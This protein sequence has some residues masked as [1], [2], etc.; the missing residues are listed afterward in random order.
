MHIVEIRF[1]DGQELPFPSRN[2]AFARADQAREF[3]RRIGI[4][5]KHTG[6]V[7]IIGPERIDTTTAARAFSDACEW[8]NAGE[9]EEAI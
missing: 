2:Y 3:A 1:D 6:R 7:D 5:T 9:S 4:A 8:I